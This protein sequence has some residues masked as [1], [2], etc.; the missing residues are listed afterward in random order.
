M[1][2]DRGSE[3]RTFALSPAGPTVSP[4]A[5]HRLAQTGGSLVGA[6]IDGTVRTWLASS[7]G[8]LVLL[9]WPAGFAARF[10][11]LEVLDGD[12]RVVASGGE[13]VVVGGGFLKAMDPRGLGHEEVF[14]ANPIAEHGDLRK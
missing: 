14:A 7:D 3:R 8:R 11:P 13:L 12:G 1:T 2:S 9:M 5:A 4:D 6:V 10:D